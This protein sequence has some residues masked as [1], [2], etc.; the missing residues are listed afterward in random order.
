MKNHPT[1]LIK[2]TSGPNKEGITLHFNEKVAM[3]PGGLTTDTWWVSWDKIGTALFP[4][5][6]ARATDMET[7]RALRG[8]SD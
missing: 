5:N 8:K 7:L 1:L 6:Y 4:L 3:H 2:G